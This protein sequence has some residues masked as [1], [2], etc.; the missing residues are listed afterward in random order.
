LALGWIEEDFF[1]LPGDGAEVEGFGPI[2]EE[3]LEELLEELLEQH[4]QALIVILIW[5]R[6][7]GHWMRP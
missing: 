3:A 7:I 5:F 4:L 6:R 2:G 1:V